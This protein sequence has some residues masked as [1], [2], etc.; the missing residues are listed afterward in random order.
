VING[1]LNEFYE[2]GAAKTRVV[3]IKG[4]GLRKKGRLKTKKSGL[5]VVTL[6][7]TLNPVSQVLW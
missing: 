3:R 6:I 1:L 5:R 2:V 7:A 4:I